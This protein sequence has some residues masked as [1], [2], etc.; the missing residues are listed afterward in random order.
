ME[1]TT[2]V[3]VAVYCRVSSE[4][5]AERGTIDVQKDF[6]L[7]YTTL[8]KLA[9]YDYYCDDGVSGTIPMKERPEGARLLQDA[10]KKLFDTVIFYKLDRI[11]RKTT[12]ILEAI[13]SLTSQGINVRSMLEPLDTNTPT[14]KFLI[15][16]L[17]GIAELDRD[18][19]LMRM[20]SG[21]LVAAKKGK[22]LGGIV[23]F[24]YLTDKDGYLVVNTEKIAGTVYSEV[25]I[26][27]LIFHMCADEGKGAKE[28]A[29]YINGLGI[30]TRFTF[31]ESVQRR[32]RPGKRLQNNAPRWGPSR[33]LRMIHSTLY[34]GYRTYGERATLKDYEP[35]LQQV[36]SIVDEELWDKANKALQTRIII[37]VKRKQGKYLLQGYLYC[38]HC[39]HTYC[40]TYN[41]LRNNKATYY[42]RCNGRDAYH[43]DYR[44]TEAA[45][46]Q[47]EW[48]EH[49]IL[50]YCAKILREHEFMDNTKKLASRENIISQELAAAKKALNNL[51]QENDRILSLY[52]KNLITM[53]ELTIQRNEIK[54]EKEAIEKRIEELQQPTFEER[55][56]LNRQSSAEFFQK[57]RKIFP[58]DYDLSNLSYQTQREILALFI[59]RITIYTE[60]HSSNS[61]YQNF[62]IEILDKF[63]ASINVAISATVRLKLQ[64]DKIGTE[65]RTVGAKLRS[66][67]LERGLTQKQVAD[68]VGIS[69]YTINA[70]ENDRKKKSGMPFQHQTIRKLA[71]FYSVPYEEIMRLQYAKIES[72]EKL[73]FAQ[74]RDIKG[75]TSNELCQ[76]IGVSKRTFR[77]YLKGRCTS[78]TRN[79]IKTFFI[80]ARRWLQIQMQSL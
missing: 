80:T 34:K 67:R 56:D 48:I 8:Y 32:K 9:V 71:E 18:T 7:Q 1:T 26:V 17:S 59:E 78:Y 6:A 45:S 64:Q 33:I 54:E 69:T 77:N 37:S 51:S 63:G 14:G 31:S 24:G 27:K 19:I 30:P 21:A 61:Y 41:R 20:H 65:I 49:T 70:F 79:K 22:W 13:Q 29:D 40:G 42:Y 74:I 35:I 66:L 5:Q 46:I 55:I 52:R 76:E 39:G 4:D 50:D 11:G 25:D 16:T 12:V 53:D 62:R 68:A 3:K 73:L 15:T 38:G 75:I 72:D 23:P 47:A 28:I 44:C 57:F 60:K 43:P 58:Q 36:P 10:E 2:I